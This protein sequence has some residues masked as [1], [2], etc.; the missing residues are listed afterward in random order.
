MERNVKECSYNI[1]RYMNIYT[2]CHQKAKYDL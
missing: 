1:L 2:I